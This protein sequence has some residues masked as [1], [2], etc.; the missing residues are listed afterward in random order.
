VKMQK[1]IRLKNGADCLIRSAAAED[2]EA[3]MELYRRTHEETDFLASY[4]DEKSLELETE[5]RFLHE[6]GQSAREAQLLAVMDGRIVGMAGIGAIGRGEKRAHRAQFGISVLRDAWGRGIG[7][8]LTAACIACAREA[9][10]AQLELEA[11]AEN[12]AALALYRSFGF[13]EYGRNPRGFRSRF[14]GWQELVLMRLELDEP[15]KT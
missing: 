8:A 12:G 6:A 1:R 4:A 13:A 2:A 9:G 7:R 14:S 10:F 3:V 5:R 11:V 15:E